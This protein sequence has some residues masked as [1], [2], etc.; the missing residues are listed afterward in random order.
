MARGVKKQINYEEEIFA[1]EN[2]INKCTLKLECLKEKLVEL[3]EA[4][5][6]QDIMSLYELLETNNISI[7]T[8]FE[9]LD[10][11]KVS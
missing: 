4:K 7:N 8:I 11:K 10:V 9:L 3:T 2:H 6:T 1:I 5:K